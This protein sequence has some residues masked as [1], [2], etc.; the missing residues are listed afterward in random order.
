MRGPRLLAA[1][2]P[3]VAAAD[4]QL[5][6]GRHFNKAITVRSNSPEDPDQL[7]LFLELLPNPSISLFTLNASYPVV[8]TGTLLTVACWLEKVDFVRALLGE[9]FSDDEA[10]PSALRGWVDPD[11]PDA[12]GGTGLMYSA[13]SGHLEIA[14]LL[15]SP[16]CLSGMRPVRPGGLTL[17]ARSASPAQ[18][19][20]GAR[21][22]RT[23]NSGLSAIWH[24]T[25]RP[26]MTWLLEDALRKQR[27]KEHK[28]SRRAVP[29]TG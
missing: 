29:R 16:S 21:P 18:L 2:S 6:G 26:Q 5:A 14:Q 12:R 13:V 19:S 25:G 23:E 4:R 17:S 1:S 15:V 24:S 9:T 3:A 11:G 8:Q 27:A 22:D 20:Q 7:S 28:V 10:T